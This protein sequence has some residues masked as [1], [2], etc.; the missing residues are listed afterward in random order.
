MHNGPQQI[1]F[2]NKFRVKLTTNK[3][4]RTE[5]KLILDRTLVVVDVTQLLIVQPI[6]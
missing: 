2:L 5:K 1:Y 3:K 4:K 6:P